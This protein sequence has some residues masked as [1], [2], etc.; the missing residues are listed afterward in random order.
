MVYT[1]E[2]VRVRLGSLADF[3]T[4]IWGTVAVRARRSQPSTR[5]ALLAAVLTL[6]FVLL[7]TVGSSDDD[8]ESSLGGS[9]DPSA[10]DDG[11]GDPTSSA[12]ADTPS[13]L[14]GP[15]DSPGTDQATETGPGVD[16]GDVADG[17]DANGDEQDAAAGFENTTRPNSS[18]SGSP[19]GRS[20]GTSGATT[21]TTEP[22][23]PEPPALDKPPLG[24]VGGLVGDLLGLV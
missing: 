15:G 3:L 21:T 2:P 18:S 1:M 20:R 22:L 23:V 8:A 4:A 24:P 19:V 9:A 7:Q 16:V 5:V 13:E 17:G 12:D 10:I 14:D 6:G 11:S